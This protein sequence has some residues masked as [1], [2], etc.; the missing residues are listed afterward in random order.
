M[1]DCLLGELNRRK[2]VYVFLDNRFGFL[3]KDCDNFYEAAK[4]FQSVYSEDIE[5]EFPEEYSQ[6]QKLFPD[7]KPDE[8][9]KALKQLGIEHSFPNVD[10]CL[11]IFLSMPI[12]NSSGERCFSALKRIKSNDRSSLGQK[13]LNW[14][15]LLCIESDITVNLDFED[16]ISSFAE[17]KCRK[18]PLF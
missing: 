12:S 10:T 14:L 3:Y 4:N 1:C 13:K 7:S 15:S 6:F 17:K 18:K 16:I 8:Q 11:R 5:D 2:D 9:L